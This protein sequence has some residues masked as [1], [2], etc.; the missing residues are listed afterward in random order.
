MFDTR[1]IRRVIISKQ[2]PFLDVKNGLEK[3]VSWNETHY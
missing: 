3:T 1:T 2:R